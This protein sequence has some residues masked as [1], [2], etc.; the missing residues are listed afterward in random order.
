MMRG[1]GNVARPAHLETTTVETSAMGFS[2]KDSPF[3]GYV[4]RNN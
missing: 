2:G 4:I 3:I 1:A